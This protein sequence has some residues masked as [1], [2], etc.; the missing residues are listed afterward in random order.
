M[1]EKAWPGQRVRNS[2]WKFSRLVSSRNGSLFY[3]NYKWTPMVKISYHFR[4]GVEWASE[5]WSFS[6]FYNAVPYG[7]GYAYVVRVYSS[8]IAP[9]VDCQVTPAIPAL[10]LTG[11]YSVGKVLIE[12][13]PI[14]TSTVLRSLSKTFSWIYGT[15]CFSQIAFSFG[16]PFWYWS[17]ERSGHTNKNVEYWKD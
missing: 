6:S 17:M 14:M 13:L 2:F 7:G 11:S 8:S 15:P 16:A 1:W 10:S 12:V 5:R 4:A 3:S 9:L